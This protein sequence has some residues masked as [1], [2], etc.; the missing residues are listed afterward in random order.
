MAEPRYDLSFSGALVAETDPAWARARLRELFRLDE[1]GC[2]RLF[3]GTPVTVKRDVDAQTA[4]QYQ[5]VFRNAGA[6]LDLLPCPGDDA[7]TAP[8]P[9]PAQAPAPGSDA[10]PT[11]GAEA[12]A[13]IP[14]ESLAL[15][16]QEGFLE[17]EPEV[18]I[19][20]IDIGHLQLV[21]GSDWSLEDCD[22]PPP[23]IPDPDISR[24]SLE[25]IEP[26]E[27]DNSSPSFI[28]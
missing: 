15:S 11:E 4:A 18:K 9:P 2:E 23:P 20:P 24:L 19:P 6:V 27:D 28:D 14:A 25:Q 7:P 3:S 22:S 8:P 21:D 1:A 26:R 17:A 10:G 13:S 12:L 16:A 5:E